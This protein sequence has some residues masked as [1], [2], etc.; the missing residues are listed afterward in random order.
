MD[1]ASDKYIFICAEKKKKK[2]VF[3]LLYHFCTIDEWL[4]N[5]KASMT[6]QQID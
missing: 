1:E 4:V 5:E 3:K 2:L 6:E